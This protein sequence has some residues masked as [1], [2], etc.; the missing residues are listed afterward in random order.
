M[1]QRTKPS[2]QGVLSPWKVCRV[3]CA[4][5]GLIQELYVTPG[6]VVKVG[7]RL[8]CLDTDQQQILVLMAQVQAQASGKVDSARAEV[9][10]HQRKLAAIEAGRKNNFTTQ[11]ELERAEVELRISLGRLANELDQFQVEQLNLKKLE[12]QL[13][14]RTVTAPIAGTVVRMFKEVGEYVAPTSPDI[15]EIVDTSRLRATFFLTAD[16]VR[17]LQALGKASVELDGQTAIT[18]ELECIAPVADGE[19]GLIEVRLLISNPSR[20]V[21]GSSCSLLLETDTL[22]QQT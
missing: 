20:Q 18:A 4:E 7:D 22:K 15:M 21:I 13:Q 10:L 11:S 2:A 16:E 19:S 17:R 5:S 1:S 9:D 12:T 14:Q 3:A 8:G 6:A